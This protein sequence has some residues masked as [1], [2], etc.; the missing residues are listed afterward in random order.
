M[1]LHSVKIIL[2]STFHFS[3]P[4]EKENVSSEKSLDFERQQ[5]ASASES[6]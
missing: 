5:S 3:T 2:L 4:T 6:Q 1:F